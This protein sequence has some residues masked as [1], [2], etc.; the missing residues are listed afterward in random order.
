MQK[1]SLLFPYLIVL[2]DSFT[3]AC[4]SLSLHS[5][6]LQR[7]AF[8]EVSNDTCCSALSEHRVTWA[9]SAFL[10]AGLWSHLQHPSAVLLLHHRLQVAGHIKFSCIVVYCDG[11]T[12]V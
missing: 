2:S 1:F 9:G 8:K 12:V 4:D 5:N 10:C 7:A 3:I 11:C 6:P